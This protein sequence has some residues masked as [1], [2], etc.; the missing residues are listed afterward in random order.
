MELP[1]LEAHHRLLAVIHGLTE[2][3]ALAT[4]ALK[5]LAALRGQHLRRPLAELSL[6]AL[7]MLV[8][9]AALQH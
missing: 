5:R 6:T 2:Q 7:G 4:I 8:A 9:R 1:E 3:L